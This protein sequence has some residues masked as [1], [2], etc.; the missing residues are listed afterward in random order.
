MAAAFEEWG[1]DWREKEWRTELREK[2]SS[3]R[4]NWGGHHGPFATAFIAF[5]QF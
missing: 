2:E 5:S 3:A 4:G 1:G